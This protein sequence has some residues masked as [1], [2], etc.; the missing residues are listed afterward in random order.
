MEG[1]PCY[2]LPAANYTLMQFAPALG[3]FGLAAGLAGW[4]YEV[5]WAGWG[6][7]AAG[8]M[9]QV[10]GV[11]AA[12]QRLHPPAPQTSHL[13]SPAPTPLPVQRALA[14]HGG[15]GNTCIGQDCFQATFITLAALGL[16]ATVA[17]TVLYRRERQVY[18]AEYQ[19]VQAYDEE[20]QR[21]GRHSTSPSPQP[22]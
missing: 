11:T 7:A 10:W 22:R 2:P 12:Q 16:V 6:Q 17:A 3:A 19:E 21:H 14:R 9:H 13:H 18:A 1:R 8:D 5:R 15:E 4:L 20:V